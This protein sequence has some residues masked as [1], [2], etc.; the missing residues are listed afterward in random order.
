MVT[1]DIRVFLGFSNSS[2]VGILY[3]FVK[4]VVDK[5]IIELCILNIYIIQR[6]KYENTIWNEFFQKLGMGDSTTRVYQLMY[7]RNYSDDTKII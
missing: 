6:K 4:S 7:C 5:V 2:Q 3:R 1:F